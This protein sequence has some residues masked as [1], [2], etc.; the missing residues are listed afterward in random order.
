MNFESRA[1][2]VNGH[3]KMSVSILML[4]KFLEMEHSQNFV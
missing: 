3:K 4:G 1:F 2:N